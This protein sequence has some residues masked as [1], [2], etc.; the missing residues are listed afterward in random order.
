MD[1]I[2]RIFPWEA[3]CGCCVWSQRTTSNAEE[4]EAAVRQPCAYPEPMVT[5]PAQEHKQSIILLHGRGSTGTM[6]GSSLLFFHV[7]GIGNLR[8][9]FPN[10]RFVFPTAANRRAA[11]LKRSMIHQWFDIWSLKDPSNREHLQHEGL[12]ETTAHIHDLLRQEIASVGASNVVLG[13]LSQGCA[14]ALIALMTWQGE[15][16]AAAVGMCGWLPLSNHLRDIA[17]QGGPH[18][19]PEDDQ[20]IFSRPDEKDGHRDS[21]IRQERKNGHS[22]G[23]TRAAGYL[24]EELEL[25][26]HGSLPSSTWQATSSAR[27]P[28][29]LGHG[30]QDSKVLPRL[31]RDAADCL[32]ALEM[33]VVHKEYAGLGHWYSEDMLLDLVCFLREALHN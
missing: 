5:P 19:G 13:G 20:V 8:E 21:S 14:A 22:N 10:A 9:A 23:P 1:R 3:A 24:F 16:V 17:S 26:T 30:A 18:D 4:P 11:V 29:F 2:L 15:P 28:V 25:P 33:S 12:R 7:P 32:R 27:T 6:F 31:G